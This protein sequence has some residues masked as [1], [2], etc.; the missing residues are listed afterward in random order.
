MNLCKYVFYK[1]FEKDPNI[2][3]DKANKELSDIL[4]NI[5]EPFGVFVTIY[6]KQINKSNIH[7]CIGEYGDI[8]I[9]K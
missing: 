1:M 3:I 6:K 7:G 5:K 9:K 4:K 8:T 2:N